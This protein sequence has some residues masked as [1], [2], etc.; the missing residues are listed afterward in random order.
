MQALRVDR[1]GRVHGAVGRGPSARVADARH[2]ALR[3]ARALLCGRRH[4]ARLVPE[5]APVQ[6]AAGHGQAARR[7]SRPLHLRHTL[8]LRPPLRRHGM[9]RRHSALFRILY[10]SFKNLPYCEKSF[11]KN[12]GKRHLDKGGFHIHG[13][14]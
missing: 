5:A 10:E 9:D 6:R 7:R 4:G 12:V 2:A 11:F 14:W 8:P 3:A 1:Q 13:V